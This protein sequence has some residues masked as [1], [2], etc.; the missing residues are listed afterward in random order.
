M[1]PRVSIAIPIY[2]EEEG[3]EELIRR[4]SAVLDALPGGPHELV[5]VDDGSADRSLE[6]LEEAARRDPRVVVVS[7]SRNFGHQQAIC[8]GLDTARGDVVVVMDGDLQDAPEAIPRFLET[9]AR[10][11]D[12]VY[13]R[14]VR[15]KEGVLLRLCYF[16]FYRLLASFSSVQVPLDAGDFSLMSRRVVD[17][18]K[19]TPERLRF[20]RGLRSWVGFRQVGIDVE[21]EERHAGSPKYGPLKLLRLAFD[22]IFAFS[23]VPLRA[24]TALGGLAILASSLFALY[25]LYKRLVLDQS[26]E[27]FTA[28]LLAVVFLAGVQLLFLGLIGEYVGRVYEEAKGRPVYIVARII[29]RG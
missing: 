28:L 21:R 9:H 10:G 14:R 16:L 1:T 27:G 26:P 24:A 4:T 20:V 22:G 17:A 8:A 12:V 23:M 7:L 11:F 15:R 29:G 25:A 18:L 19:A 3:I 6:L 2:N 5:L 13:A